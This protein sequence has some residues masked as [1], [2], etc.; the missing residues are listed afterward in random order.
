MDYRKLLLL[1]AAR[2]TGVLNA[3]VSNAQTPEDVAAETGVTE[4]AA[5]MTVDALLDMG[6]LEDVSRGVEPTNRMLGFVTKTDV[7][8]IG[9]LPHHLNRVDALVDLPE[10]MQTGDVPERGPDWTRNRLGDQAAEDDAWVRAAVT[11]AVRERPAAD[12]VL[13]VAGG[14]GQHAVEFARRGFDVTM[15]DDPA[16][17]EAV[18]PLLEHER[19]DLVA[20]NPLDGVDGDHDG[21]G[22]FDIVFHARVAREHGPDDNRRLLVSAQRAASEGGLAIH[23]DSF[24]TEDGD[25]GGTADAALTAEL[26]ATTADGECHEEA[27]VG[28]WFTDAGFADVRA[29]DVP[30]TPYRFVAGDRR[31]I[32]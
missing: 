16:V 21:D 26:L 11:T 5:V 27:A 30:G 28:E 7:R 15:L 1:R 6:L 13:V 19:V 32:Q 18:T 2:E 17:V 29:S 14:A 3:L 23:V 22:D 8:S 10:T 31:S 20:G 4:R 24:A 25:S 9:Q 12:S